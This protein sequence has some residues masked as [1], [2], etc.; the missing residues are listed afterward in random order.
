MRKSFEEIIYPISISFASQLFFT[1]DSH[2]RHTAVVDSHHL[3]LS[4][5]AVVDFFSTLYFLFAS[6]RL[7][8]RL[9]T[10]ILPSGSSIYL[11][12][13]ALQWTLARR[14]SESETSEEGDDARR[15]EEE[16]IFP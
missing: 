14:A 11:L 13:A 12:M 5:L 9:L 15:E 6:Q 3:E 4:Y 7:V 16:N 8:S 10:F 2:A 1:V